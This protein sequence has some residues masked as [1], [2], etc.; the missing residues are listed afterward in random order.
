MPDI[1]PVTEPAAPA[2]SLS[3]V[4]TWLWAAVALVLLIG[5]AGLLLGWVRNDSPAPSSV[6]S[7]YGGQFALVDRTGKTVSNQTLAGTPYAIFFGFTRC[8]DVCPT[9][10]SRMA[11]LRGQLGADGM[12][13]RIIFVSVDPAH[14]SPETVG[15][16]VDLFGT[17]I[18]GLTGSE[19]QIATAKKGFGIYAERVPLDPANPAGDYTIDHTAAIFL[20]NAR[21]ELTGT[22]DHAEPDDSARDKLARL[23]S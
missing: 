3:T 12:K 20:M 13:F 4:R 9:S 8:P 18:L 11:R 1:E 6:A 10:L 15:N 16:F 7:T 5:I 22:I 14:D 21:G 17:P 2:A 23:V 19:A